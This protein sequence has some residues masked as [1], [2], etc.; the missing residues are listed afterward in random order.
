MINI[1]LHTPQD[2]NSLAELV[3]NYLGH[4]YPDYYEHARSVLVRQ[5]R[6]LLL[7]TYQGN[8]QRLEE[9]FLAPGANVI[10]VIKETCAPGQV[11]DLE[12]KLI[13]HGAVWQCY[14]TKTEDIVN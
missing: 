9:E 14:E 6:D 4:L 12:S 3:D 2:N 5:T 11:S 13:P 10:A 7:C 8:L 1:V